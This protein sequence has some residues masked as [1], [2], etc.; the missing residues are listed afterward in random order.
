MKGC[1]WHC[2]GGPGVKRRRTCGSGGGDGRSDEKRR[3]MKDFCCSWL[4]WY[5]WKMKVVEDGG[6]GH[7]EVLENYWKRNIKKMKD[8]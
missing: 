1:R 4:W 8:C 2:S 6:D 3:K 5:G 7:S